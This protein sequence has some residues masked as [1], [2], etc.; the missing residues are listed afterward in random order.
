MNVGRIAD[1]GLGLGEGG[2]IEFRQP[3]TADDW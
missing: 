2:E 3:G 1:N